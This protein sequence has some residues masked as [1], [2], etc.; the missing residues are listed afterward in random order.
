MEGGAARKTSE[1]FLLDGVPAIQ[2]KCVAATEG[3]TAA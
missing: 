3:S 1:A 2:Q